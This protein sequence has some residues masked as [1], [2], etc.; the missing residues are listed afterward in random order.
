MDPLAMTE[1]KFWELLAKAR[2][3]GA[4]SACHCC[5]KRY[6]SAFGN[7]EVSE[8][9]LKLYDKICD[10][11]DWRLW[12]AGEL[13]TP[14][15]S[16]DSFHYFRTWIV[17]VG[18]RAFDAA[19]KD[20]D[21]L[22]IFVDAIED[23]IDID[24]EALEYVALDILRERGVEEDPRDRSTRSADDAPAGEPFDPHTLAASY[25]KLALQFRNRSMSSTGEGEV[26]AA[27]R[28]FAFRYTVAWCSRKPGIVA[29]LYAP[30]GSLTINGGRPSI[31]R[32]EI[33]ETVRSFMT[34][35]PDLRLEMGH[36]LNSG[37][38]VQYHWTLAGTNTGHGG[39]GNS[40]RISGFENWKIGSDGLIL[41]SQGYFDAAEYNRQI[42]GT[43]STS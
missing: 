4:T 37:D 29:D 6:L 12:G 18:K 15:M 19:R 14:G 10:L 28:R 17:G 11:N 13:I 36:L 39:T 43:P 2:R 16:G 33:T 22:G 35:F 3:R 38:R 20:P 23:P 30:L 26:S 1:S 5:L 7:Q 42:S 32:E 41:D 27:L 25:P 9:G 24:N 31:G 34:A 8:F 40:V 21:T